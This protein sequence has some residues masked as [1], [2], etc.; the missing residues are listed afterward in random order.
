MSELHDHESLSF[1]DALFLYLER[2]GMPLNV[3]SL[4]LFD[5]IIPLEACFDFVHSKLALIPRY[6]QRVVSPPLNLGLPVWEFDRHFDLHN[7]LRE[8]TLRSGTEAELRKVTAQL[9]SDTMDRSRPLW[10]LTLLRGLKGNR[11]GLLTRVHHCM[12][13]GVS[14]VGLMNVLMDPSPDVPVLPK[15]KERLRMP[16]PS[17]TANSLVDGFVRSCFSA[18]QQVLTAQSELLNMAQQVVASAGKPAEQPAEVQPGFNS[19]PQIPSFADLARLVPEFAAAPERLPFNMICRGP[20]K[21]EWAEIPLAEIK[22]M[23][24]VCGATVNDV[25]LALVTSAVRRYAEL[26]DVPVSGRL[27]RIVVPVS[28]RGKGNANELGNRITF[29]PVSIPLEIREPRKLI[30]AVRERMGFLKSARVAEFVGL[31]G[32]LI[33]TIPT[34]LQ[35][36]VGPIASQLPLSVCNLICTNV[37]GPKMPLYLLGHKML[38]C[39]PYV[40]IG[41]ELGMNCALLTYN[42]TAYFGFTGDAHAIPDLQHLKKFLKTSFAELRKAT[43]VRKPRAPR[44]K[45]K[46]PAPPRKPKVAAAG[47]LQPPAP[48][49]IAFPAK[50]VKSPEPEKTKAFQAAMGA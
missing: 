12:A 26:H 22:A 30:A 3:A 17:D 6:R 44:R 4:S 33:G 49:V 50:D 47:P 39:Y 20:Q 7:H 37:P 10:D 18:V 35:A 46:V 45:A 2:D 36:M 11:T 34:S 14:G 5:G 40:P 48:E 27:L 24:Q 19:E 28:V 41:G 21:F 43:A 13:D 25:V 32:T 23:K 38:S 9:L 16:P 15:K 42:G 31:A 29:V 1:G 8:V